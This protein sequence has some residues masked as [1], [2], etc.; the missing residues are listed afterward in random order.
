MAF[1]GFQWAAGSR[2]NYRHDMA[3]PGSAKTALTLT[4]YAIK[5]G[6]WISKQIRRERLHFVFQRYR[7]ARGG[8]GGKSTLGLMIDFRVT[9][10]YRIAVEINRG[11]VIYW[12]GLQRHTFSR[13]Q[14]GCPFLP[15]VPAD[16]RALFPVMPPPVPEEKPFKAKIVFI[17]NYGKRYRVGK[18]TFLTH[19]PQTPYPPD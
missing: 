8:W 14:V 12:T 1:S 4:G 15:R 10:T 2:Y 11:E 16:F 18:F 9:S 17:D 13:I 5:L 7:R 3:D 6:E 19:D